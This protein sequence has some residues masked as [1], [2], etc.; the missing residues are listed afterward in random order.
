MSQIKLISQ[1]AAHSSLTLSITPFVQETPHRFLQI[2]SDIRCREILLLFGGWWLQ[3]RP[4][5]VS[6]NP[7]VVGSPLAI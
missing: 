7:D 5:R 3:F 1:T 4:K 6:L 2:D